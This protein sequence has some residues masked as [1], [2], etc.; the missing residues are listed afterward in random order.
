MW[1]YVWVGWVEALRTQKSAQVLMCACLS[2]HKYAH[3]RDFHRFSGMSCLFAGSDCGRTS[4]WAAGSASN[5]SPRRLGTVCLVT[6]PNN[7]PAG[8]LLVGLVVD[9]VYYSDESSTLYYRFQGWCLPNEFFQG[10]DTVSVR[11][12]AGD[13]ACSQRTFK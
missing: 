8:R 11:V 9:V 2:L 10:S 1:A 12:F 5:R 7:A 13:G 6:N 3:D 4:N